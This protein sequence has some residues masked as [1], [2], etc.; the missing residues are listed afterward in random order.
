MNARCRVYIPKEAFRGTWHQASN[1]ERAHVALC[2]FSKTFSDIKS[3][4][5]LFFFFHFPVV[6]PSHLDRH[7]CQ[8]K[9]SVRGKLC[10]C[11][12]VL[13]GRERDL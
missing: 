8:V 11:T 5:S 10:R 4:L 12:D 1:P 9:C 13:G 7:K 3:H 2:F 6:F